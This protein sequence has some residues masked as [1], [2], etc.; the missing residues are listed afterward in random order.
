MLE[1]IYHKIKTILFK[2]PVFYFNLPKKNSLVIFDDLN[3]QNIKSS[4]SYK[5]TYE[6]KFRNNRINFFAL[7]YALIFFFKSNL[8]IEY[9][10]FFIK[11]SKI[12]ILV[13]SNFNRLII[14]QIKKYYPHVKVIVIQNGIIGN[15]FISKI[16]NSYY[17]NLSCDYFF[18]FTKLESEKIKNLIETEFVVLGSIRNNLYEINKNNK[19]K[20][21]LFISQYRDGLIN[22]PLFRPLYKTEELLLPVVFDFCKKKNLELAILPGDEN[23]NKQMDYY[24]KLLKNGNFL[25]YSRDLKKTYQRVDDSLFSINIDSALGYE[26]LSRNNK[27]GF[28]NF[29]DFSEMS[30]LSRSF[31]KKDGSFYL[32]FYDKEKINNVLEYLYSVDDATWENQNFGEFNS[33][34]FNINNLK[35]KKILENFLKN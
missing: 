11:R 35:L 8:K 21:I 31:Y 34:P 16:K 9:I 14:Y 29:F 25:L 30:F 18:C 19:K 26:S 7:I 32:G 12:N 22:N 4:I 23:E 5:N 27:V 2:L 17:K 15:E 13:T 1:S 24:K 6:I 20:Q 10:N 33:I 3:S 28:F